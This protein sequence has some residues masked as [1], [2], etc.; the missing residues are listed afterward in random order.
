MWKTKLANQAFK[1][2]FHDYLYNTPSYLNHKR[3]FPAILP[4]T[5]QFLELVEVKMNVSNPKGCIPLQGASRY[6]HNQSASRLP[7][8][9]LCSPSNCKS[10]LVC[11]FSLYNPP[12]V[13][14]CSCTLPYMEWVPS[15]VH[16]VS[17]LAPWCTS[18]LRWLPGTAAFSLGN[19]LS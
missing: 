13:N 4:L 15:L 14:S 10:P 1:P 18:F 5:S 2:G 3:T 7:L 16:Q 8:L 11:G 19:S 9:A 12:V 17:P 6:I